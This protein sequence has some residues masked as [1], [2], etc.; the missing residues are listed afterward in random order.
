MTP[1]ITTGRPLVPVTVVVPAYNA[2]STLPRALA[3]VFAQTYLPAEI[4]VVDDAS[5]DQS[6]DVLQQLCVDCPEQPIKLVRLNQNG[7]ASRARNTGW[8]LATQEYVAFLDA[9]DAWHP[10][11]LEVQY[12]WMVDHPQVVLCG[13]RCEVCHDQAPTL[14]LPSDGVPARYFGIGSFLVANRLSTPSVMLR[15]ALGERF[16]ADKRHS[17]DA[18]LWVQIV[19]AHGPAAFIDM[20]LAF[21]F[22]AKY[23]ATGLSG[24]LWRMQ[25]GEMDTWYRLCSTGIISRAVWLAVV[26]W[27]WA[28]FVKRVMHSA[29]FGYALRRIALR[30]SQSDLGGIGCR[31]VMPIPAGGQTNKLDSEI[32]GNKDDQVVKAFGEEWLRFSQGALAKSEREEI[33]DDYFAIFPWDELSAESSGADIGCG[34]GRWAA[35]V[36]HRV[37]RLTCVDASTDALEVAQR[38]LV[39]QNNVVFRQADVGRLPFSDGALDFAYSLGVLHHVPDTEGALAEVARTLK[40]G[41]LFLV[42]LYYAFD[43]RPPWFRLLWWLLDGLRRMISRLPTS[44][45]FVVCDIIAGLVYWPLARISL[46]LAKLGALPQNFLLSY[47][48]DKSFYVMRTDALDR[49]GTRLEKRFCRDQIAAMLE[50]AGFGDIRFSAAEPFWCAVARKR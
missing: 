7:G 33:F 5:S 15:R 31:S 9:D 38:N 2:A 46:L 21:L 18:L 24:D 45:R 14:D 19:A 22:K 16:T 29:L 37:G 20:P 11:K 34:S 6:W 8:A 23:G 17:E 44:L 28:K 3:S 43:N 30:T 48:K 1:S 32:R 36:A 41:G 10:R 47:Y 4:V 27:S 35:V 26:T 42:Y 39:G 13:H 40:P 49:F 12:S 50:A 25:V